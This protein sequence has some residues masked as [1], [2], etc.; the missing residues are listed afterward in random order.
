[1]DTREIR[2][3]IEGLAK[4]RRFRGIDTARLERI[5]ERAGSRR[6]AFDYDAALSRIKAEAAREPVPARSSAPS[7]KPFQLKWKILVPALVPALMLLAIAFFAVRGR[8]PAPQG[9]VKAV[10]RFVYGD[11]H[12]E[13]SGTRTLLESGRELES[14]DVV[15]TGARGLAEIHVGTDTIVRVRE[16]S[17]LAI[18]EIQR[19]DGRLAFSADLP[20][21]TALFNFKR[22]SKG[23]SASVRTPTSVAGVRGTT[24]GVS[25]GRN[26][27][28]RYEV[29]EG[30]IRV[31]SRVDTVA[32][33]P[34]GR[35][36]EKR[37]EEAA[38]VVESG[39]I[40]TVDAAAAARLERELKSAVASQAP[41]ERIGEIV[42]AESP[43]RVGD[44]TP[45]M[46]AE[47]RSIERRSQEEAAGP[48]VFP[49]TINVTPPRARVYLDGDF[50]GDGPLTVLTTEGRH[51]VE[52][53]ADG[54][55]AKEVEETVGSNRNVITVAL[56]RDGGGL[57]APGAWR[58]NGES[59]SL[60][61]IESRDMLVN[62]T[63]KMKVEAV[64]R[65]RVLWSRSLASPVSS[66]PVWNGDSLYLATSNEKIISLSLGNGAV[67]WERPIKGILLFG[68]GIEYHN[69]LL[70]AGTSR[71][72]LYCFDSAGRMRWETKFDGGIF[73][74]PVVSRHKLYVTVQ[75]GNLYK[76]DIASG[77]V[78]GQVNVGKVIGTSRIIEG[79]KLYLANYSGEV[80]SY[81]HE[82]GA[83]DWKYN[84]GRRLI[85]NTLFDRGSLYVFNIEG[86]IFK[87]DQAGR[88]AWKTELG[89]QIRVNPAIYDHAI[90]AIAGR[91]LYQVDGEKGQVRWSYVMQS[92]PTTGVTVTRRN[93]LFGTEEKGLVVLHRD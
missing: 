61:Y 58:G 83:V 40:C 64:S 5:F 20:S 65:G 30:K 82:R 35:E 19:R 69:G 39:G 81:D 73:S 77:A 49:L 88:L 4:K 76:V 33:T 46:F 74:S 80:I 9:E 47:M 72:F 79:P 55:A 60:S 37:L 26:S 23:D 28:V 86:D 14:G 68:S 21:G 71:G 32:S 90:Y 66:D 42:K 38:V 45:T 24:F 48:R 36:V 51:R 18:A 75:D 16:G 50:R 41:A 8:I 17:R 93:I 52:V 78:E 15:A 1:M 13:R 29:L 11:A 54:F 63:T 22:F 57:N 2:T 12:L 34:A 3:I 70:F 91:V 31:K 87:L 89:G 43:V 67:R 84:T 10:C 25:V 44:E 53:K 92:N 6:D 62:V 7:R 56:E 59:S 27:D 85:V